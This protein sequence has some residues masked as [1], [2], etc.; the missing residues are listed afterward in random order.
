[1]GIQSG[2]DGTFRI[3][4]IADPHTDQDE[5]ANARTWRDVH[6][7]IDRFRPG[8]LVVLGDVWCGDDRPE[9][10]REWM[11]RDLSVIASLG[12][13]WAFVW[14]NHDY[15]VDTADGHAA[16]ATADNAVPPDVTGP[17]GD[18]R[19]AVAD[20]HDDAVLWDLF[21]LNSHTECLL[22]ED[23]EWLEQE[24]MRLRAERGR[25]V[26]ALLF[27]HIPL[28]QYETARETGRAEGIGLEEVLYW[29]DDGTLIEG[30]KRAGNVR[31]CFA[32]HS[33]RNDFY[34]VEDGVVFAYARATGYG[35]YGDDVKKGAKLITLG[36][37]T[38]H[39]E[40]VF[41]DGSTWGKIWNKLE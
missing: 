21:F 16:V 18:Y 2:Q 33:H 39:F 12:V 14:G 40:T 25:D 41:A 8:L 10:A 28:K 32:G 35:G 23:V 31:A 7:M 6:A 30:I 29:G 15:G 13:P 19:I 1:M 34:F 17:P 22:R 26:P 11:R 37:A 38:L 9:Q 27:F 5:D 3:L 4:V 24:T 20:R 36:P